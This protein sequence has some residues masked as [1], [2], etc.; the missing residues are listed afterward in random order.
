MHKPQEDNDWLPENKKNRVRY[1]LQTGETRIKQLRKFRYRKM[2]LTL[3]GKYHSEMRR[4]I[5][6]AKQNIQRPKKT[7]QKQWQE[8]EQF[9]KQYQCC[10]MSVKVR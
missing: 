2:A 8:A 3:E 5:R 9:V 7:C 10:K 1:E 4:F 6:N